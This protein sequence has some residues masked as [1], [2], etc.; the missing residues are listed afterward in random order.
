MKSPQNNVNGNRNNNTPV[1]LFRRVCSTISLFVQITPN[2]ILAILIPAI[3]GI[4]Q[5]LG[6]DPVPLALACSFGISYTITLPPHSKVNTLYFGTGYFTVADQ[7]KYGIITCFIGSV[8]ISLTYF[9]W[10]GII[11]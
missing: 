10:L 9:F 6:M 4:A 2:I 7:L 1:I 11:L 3:I 5:S 8:M